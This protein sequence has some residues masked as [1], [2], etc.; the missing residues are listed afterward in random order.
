MTIWAKGAKGGAGTCR[1]RGR[2]E[3]GYCVVEER[4][5]AEGMNAPVQAKGRFE[6]LSV[7]APWVFA[8]TVV[9]F[10]V[11]AVSTNPPQ[12][13]VTTPPDARMVEYWKEQE[14]LRGQI[15]RNLEQTKDLLVSLAREMDAQ[16]Y[17][18]E[19]LLA[20]IK[21]KREELSRLKRELLELYKRMAL[22][23]MDVGEGA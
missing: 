8:V 15:E 21:E 10:V 5:M 11:L 3:R 4:K 22:A 6:K 7:Y 12:Q 16:G 2:G 17:N 9:V 23:G 13:N 1:Y 14:R 20:Q 19:S 18:A